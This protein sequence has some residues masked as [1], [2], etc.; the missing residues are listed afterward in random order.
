MTIPLTERSRLSPDEAAEVARAL[1]A[2]DGTASELPSERDQNFRIDPGE[3]ATGTEPGGGER[4]VLK[5]SNAAERDA[6]LELQQQLLHRLRERIDDFDF[7]EPVAT[8]DGT[9]ITSIER[10]GRRHAVRMFRWLDGTPLGDA[11]PRSRE[12][13]ADLG[14]LAG[15]LGAALDGFEHPAA[16]RSLKWDLRRAAEEVEARI[17]LIVD[18]RRRTLVERLTAGAT[19]RVDAVAGDLRTGVIHNDL[20]DYNLLCGPAPIDG[21]RRRLTGLLDFG[22][23]IAGW[24]A[25]E[26]ATAIAYAILGSAEPLDVAATI[27]AASHARFPLREAEVEALFDL[28]TLRLCLSVSVAAEQ[29]AGE[30]D[31]EYLSISETQAWEALERIETIAPSLA[32]YHLRAACGLEP[33]PDG[34]RVREW[35]ARHRGTFA[36]VVEPALD[37]GELHVFDLGVGSE[38]VG[39]GALGEFD[40]PA[41]SDRLFGLM[42]TAGAPVGWGRYD[43]RRAL[44]GGDLFATD[45]DEAPRRRTLHI[46]VDLFLEPGDAVMAPLDGVVVGS[47]DNAGHLDYGPTL[48]LEHEPEPGLRFWTLY[49]HLDHGA[50]EESPVGRRVAAGDRIATIG[51]IPGNG[52]WPPHLH[53]Q[54]IAD[55]LGRDGEFPGVCAPDERATW[56]SLCPDPSLILGVDETLLEP[57]GLDAAGIHELRRRHLL[58]SLSLSYR[59]PLHIVRGFRQW[60]YDVDGQPFLDAVNNVPHVGHSHP[61]VVAAAHR[62]NELLNT[63]TR[64]LHEAIAVYAERLAATLP[65]GLDVCAFVCSGS[66]ANELAIRMA[67]VHTGRRDIVALQAGYH[68]N[69]STLVD[70]SDYKHSGPGG[71]G[72]PDWVHVAA[73][74]DPYRGIHRDA[75]AAMASRYA[76]EVER[77]CA[78]AENNGGPAAFLAE[79]LVGCGGQLVPPDG[80]LRDAFDRVRAAGGVAI[81]DEVQIGFGRVGTHMWAFEAQGAIPDIVTLGKPIG[82]GF[83]LGAVVT[84]REI[85]DSFANGMEYFNTFG[86]NPVSCAVGMAVL[87]VLET[88]N[89]QDNARVVGDRLLSGLRS[90]V[91][92]HPIAGDARGVGLYVGLELVL[93]RD[94]REPAGAVASHVAN[95]MR[96]HGILIS[97]DGPDHN[98]LKI[99]PPICFSEADADRLVETLDVVLGEDAVVSTCSGA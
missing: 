78:A 67:R 41:L 71:S 23:I 90:L 6:L 74:P 94:T 86:G 43:E 69:T 59:R 5:I 48:I 13:M 36:P 95:R 82:N 1:F 79:P 51:D 72:P 89:L 20:N 18:D 15:A 85:A 99:K 35:L 33:C 93:N 54:V 7:P 87:D 55:L 45:S 68:G 70:V 83:P 50:L 38:E 62:Q 26:T 32:R 25:A 37:A 21:S 53:F 9:E 81:A 11:R 64:Y 65:E 73:M 75:G 61:H 88:E 42:R 12:L 34:G 17:G 39:G 30:P 28:A 56:L 77:A 63:N 31:N 49:G 57:V 2:R 4:F 46:G 66:E 97:T 60:L 3:E 24:R 58:P 44:Y 92:R 96:D 8:I 84:T 76:D 29:R 52:N 19:G 98:V 22:D 14:K 47:R 27:A 80:Y 16:E 91:D 10:D 40:T